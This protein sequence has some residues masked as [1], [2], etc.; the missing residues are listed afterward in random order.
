M[1]I[2]KTMDTP[3]GTGAATSVVGDTAGPSQGEAAQRSQRGQKR[4]FGV[5][6]LKS[7]PVPADS[8]QHLP[9]RI[10]PR[11]LF[12]HMH[13]ERASELTN[14]MIPRYEDEFQRFA[15]GQASEA[16]ASLN[17]PPKLRQNPVVDMARAHFT[18]RNWN[19]SASFRGAKPD[20]CIDAIRDRPD[21]VLRTLIALRT[22]RTAD[23]DTLVA[24]ARFLEE[25]P[26]A[27]RLIAFGEGGK[28]KLKLSVDDEKVVL[29]I[30]LP[31]NDSRQEALGVIQKL[32][33]AKGASKMLGP[34]AL[35]VIEEHLDA[36]VHTAANFPED[37][38]NHGQDP[39]MEVS[40][41]LQRSG[42]ALAAAYLKK[43]SLAPAESEVEK[44]S[45]ATAKQ[46][47]DNLQMNGRTDLIQAMAGLS[48]G[49][50]WSLPRLVKLK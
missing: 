12:F 26:Q 37:Q 44:L 6:G 47:F 45:L 11:A 10:S 36:A 40:V 5:S 25:V 39:L 48:K 21:D 50:R 28:D 49:G 32:I 8:G 14:D 38:G 29:D 31:P 41:L 20:A 18:D 7:R 22:G 30:L 43:G 24:A 35:A 17:E 2:T 4:H 3:L 15:K 9:P 33:S 23:E 46:F 34:D 1:K 19:P 42:A 13:A 27:L 16:E